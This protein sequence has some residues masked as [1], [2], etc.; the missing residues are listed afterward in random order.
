M[1]ERITPNQTSTVLS[2][3]TDEQQRELLAGK[4]V[5]LYRPPEG[6]CAVVDVVDGEI[7][8]SSAPAL[9]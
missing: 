9:N 3:L 7:M 1:S 4:T 5:E 6:E 2:K 8:F